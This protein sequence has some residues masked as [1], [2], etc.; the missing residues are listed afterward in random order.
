MRY[1]LLLLPLFAIAEPLSVDQLFNVQT[2][3]V[4]AEDATHKE[5]F[6]GYV[7]ADD[8]RRYDVTPRYGG[9]IEK[10]HADTQYAYV[11]KGDALAIVYSPEVTRA[12]EEYRS[13]LR[14]HRQHG[15]D[16]MLGSARQKL[17]LLGVDAAEIDAAGD[18]Q[19]DLRQTVIHAPVSGYLFSKSVNSGSA[20]NAKARL[21]EIVDLSGVWVEARIPEAKLSAAHAKRFEIR[22]EALNKSYKATAALLYPDIGAKEALA[23][24][25]L[26]VDNPERALF[27]GLYVTITASEAPQRLLSLPES[28]VIRKEGKWYAFAVGEYEGEYE[29]VE[30]KVKRLNGGRYAILEGLEAGREVVSNALFMMD[31]DAQIN[32]LY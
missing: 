10:L 12:K 9:Y 30:V 16:A 8:S 6:Y 15:N 31:S 13:T 22:S 19:S 24:L 2:V 17:E 14:Y 1:L 11:T 25:R 29:P 5:R 26:S 7:R 4:Q 18:A 27:P 3:T 28:A 21:F 20:F 23:T 32:G